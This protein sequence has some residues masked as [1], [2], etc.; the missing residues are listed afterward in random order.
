MNIISR[1]KM[2]E[3]LYNLDITNEEIKDMINIYPSIIELTNSAYP[4]N[5]YQRTKTSILTHLIRLY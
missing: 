4:I 2:M 3:K 1:R 5:K